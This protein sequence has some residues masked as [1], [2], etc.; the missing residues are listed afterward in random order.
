[1]AN[2]VSH[3]LIVASGEAIVY[4]DNRSL[5]CRV[6]GVSTDRLVAI[7]PEPAHNGQPLRLVFKLDGVSG[8]LDADA[9]VAR[10]VAKADDPRQQVWT[11]QLRPMADPSRQLVEDFVTQRRHVGKKTGPGQTQVR[12]QTRLGVGAV[13]ARPGLQ[14]RVS[15]DSQPRIILD[16]ILQAGRTY[17]K[18]RRR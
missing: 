2:D 6:T 3:D 18:F 16:D 1:M 17:H 13:G 7:S 11:L 15:D 9:T 14:P 5:R 8:W 12:P 4:L 10:Q